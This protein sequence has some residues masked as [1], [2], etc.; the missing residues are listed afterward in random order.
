MK[1]PYLRYSR[2]GLV[3][4]LLFMG[5]V[6][7]LLYWL[8]FVDVANPGSSGEAGVWLLLPASP[9]VFLM[10]SDWLGLPA[11]IAAFLLNAV[12]LYLIAGGIGWR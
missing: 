4:A 2:R 6:A 11:A 5:V 1:R 9:W 3:L 12:L 10:P 7:G 8:V